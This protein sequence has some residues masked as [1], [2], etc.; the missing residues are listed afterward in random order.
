MLYK[1]NVHPVMHYLL[2]LGT[3]IHKSG[4]GLRLCVLLMVWDNGNEPIQTSLCC[5]ASHD[6]TASTVRV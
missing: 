1:I 4:L 2:Q 3:A 6:L 5:I